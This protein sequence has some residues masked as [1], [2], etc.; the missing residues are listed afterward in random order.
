MA[1]PIRNWK[2]FMA[3]G[4]T[5]GHL[6]DKEAR[7]KALEF[8]RRLKP[9]KTFDLGDLIDTAAFRS[10]A[11]GS[12]DETEPTEPEVVSTKLCERVLHS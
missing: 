2:P 6:V 5:H 8:K 3:V 4:C 11:R 9:K 10:G 1:N 12:K 7:K